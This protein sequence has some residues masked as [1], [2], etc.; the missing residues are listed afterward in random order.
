MSTNSAMPVND[1]LLDVPQLVIHVGYPKAGSTSL[2]RN[3]LIENPEINLLA[4]IRPPR[5]GNQLQRSPIT[6]EFYKSIHSYPEGFDASQLKQTWRDHFQSWVREDQLN[7]LTS[8]MFTVNRVPVL[9]VARR[10]GSLFAE[11]RIFMVLRQQTEVLRSLYDMYP[12]APGT[13]DYVRFD[14]W[15]ENALTN[16]HES[17]AGSL[18]YHS[19]VRAYQDRFGADRTGVFLF[20]ELYRDEASMLRAAQ[21]LGTDPVATKARLQRKAENAASDHAFGALGRRILGRFHAS[22]IFP[23]QAVR[24]VKK[25]GAKYYKGKQTVLTPQQARRI[26]EFYA[27]DNAATAALLGRDLG[28]LG[29]PVPS[30]RVAFG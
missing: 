6:T 19:V 4:L 7:V 18:K 3:L 15:L 23:K 13:T 21:F 2:Q 29:Y 5:T 25:L 1:S 12:Y 16:Q 30:Q 24:A 28:A 11:A 20:E 10:L 9:E 8:E 17:I 26:D 27:D 14:S 22:Q